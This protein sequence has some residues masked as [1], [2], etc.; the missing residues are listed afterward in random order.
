MTEES[1]HRGPVYQAACHCRTVRF[2][3]QLVTDGLRTARRCNCSYCSMR[4]AVMV[5]ADLKNIEVLQGQEALTLYQF[6]TR[7]ARHYF[8]RHCGIYTFHQR[9]SSP[10]Q[11]GV[12]VACIEG[13]GPFD[14]AEVPVVQG[15][16]HP[17]DR[18]SGGESGSGSGSKPLVAV[19]GW[20]RYEDNQP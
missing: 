4:G 17:G 16:A 15:R 7:V 5:F 18:G 2:T 8:C 19:A 3:V 1:L 14:F 20:V 10:E 13:M 11:Y 6:N 9:R 12:N